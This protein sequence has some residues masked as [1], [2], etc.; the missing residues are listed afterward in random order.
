MK[1]PT[2]MTSNLLKPA[3]MALAVSACGCLFSEDAIAVTT[4]SAT[5]A[6]QTDD[7]ILIDLAKELAEMRQG[8]K[9]LADHYYRLGLEQMGRG[10]SM[11]AVRSLRVAARSEPGN[12]TYA[13][14]LT[15]AEALAGTTTEP[16]SIIA[17]DLGEQYDAHLQEQWTEIQRRIKEGERHLEQGNYAQAEQQ[18]QMAQL[19]LT[20]LPPSQALR[21]SELRKVESLIEANKQRRGQEEIARVTDR[22]QRAQEE[23]IARNRHEVNMEKQRIDMLL[24]RALRSCERKDYDQC[25]LL[26]RQVLKLN[27]ADRRAANLLAESQRERHAYL[28]KIT[29][30]RWDE[31]HKLLSENIRK[32]LIPQLEIVVYADDWPEI[33]AR[34][35]VKTRP[36][37]QTTEEVWRTEI[38]RR[39]KQVLDVSFE[40]ASLADIIT[41]F[42]TNTGINFLL[43]PRAATGIAPINLKLSG[44]VTAEQALNHLMNITKLQYSLKDEVI[45]VSTQVGVEGDVTT[46]TYD[47]KDLTIGITNYP[48]PVVSMPTGSGG[49][50][51]ITIPEIP[52]K[53]P[54]SAEEIIDIIKAVVPGNWDQPGRRLEPWQ[55]G[56][57]LVRQTPEV[58]KKIENL[59]TVLR[60][61]RAVQ[62]HVKLRFLQ[63][64]NTQLES[65][66][67]AFKNFSGAAVTS[68]NAQ[69]SIDGQP[70]SVRPAGANYPWQFGGYYNH[71]D[72]LIGAAR[73]D[74]PLSDYYSFGNLRPDN[75]FSSNLQI[76]GKGNKG[77]I[78]AWLFEMVEKTRQGN[79]VHEP[80]LTLFSGQRAYVANLQ[81]QAYISDYEVVNGSYDPTI[82]TLA[83]GIVLDVEAFA[84]AD[85]RYIT[86][87]LQPQ[88]A[89]VG[90]WRRFGPP[91]D[92]F[93]GGNVVQAGR[94]IGY[95]AGLLEYPL[96]IPQITY[97]TVRTTVTIPDRGSILLGGMNRSGTAR[98]HTGVPFLSH[99][100]FL[101]RL[102]SSTGRTE[103]EYKEFIYVSADLI[104]LEEIEKNNF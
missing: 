3:I 12:E 27:G 15:R 32:T 53:A 51:A 58:H 36:G 54:P 9:A 14:A 37:D 81:Q 92:N 11:E 52:D 61:Q 10:E 63:V 75:G 16:R 77:P 7:A 41:F 91:T 19:R 67:S 99:I 70:V 33:D 4:P 24:R 50:G 73:N 17:V 35:T 100:P 87:T 57:L 97:H 31:E 80:D 88:E 34:R 45:Y 66:Q 72:W 64:E 20:T 83:T 103:Q 90:E 13:K 89:R 102:F 8:K 26:C 48:G 86:M 46:K 69:G 96:T 74:N 1:A 56:Y 76:Y 25:I 71:Q 5:K 6:S 98:A 30:D 55:A 60:N 79:I 94:G 22:G 84:S 21:D 59:L 42:Q 40:G 93:P 68:D 23:A 38:K 95:I 82:S 29:A 62:I 28:R 101:G 49:T 39:L 2:N 43:D 78:G 47:V 18:F 85:R 44:G 65:F 104:L